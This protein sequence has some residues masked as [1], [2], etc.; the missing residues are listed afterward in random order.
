M[1]RTGRRL[2]RSGRAFRTP[3]G[4]TPGGGRPETSPR[5]AAPLTPPPPRARQAAPRRP[6]PAPPAG[7]NARPHSRDGAGPRGTTVAP[8]V[9][10]ARHAVSANR[11]TPQPAIA[12]ALSAGRRRRLFSRG[13]VASHLIN[14]R[15]VRRLRAVEESSPEKTV[16]AG[17][18]RGDRNFGGSPAAAHPERAG[19]GGDVGVTACE[20]P[21]E[22]YGGSYAPPSSAAQTSRPWQP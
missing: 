15:R 21:C 14:P 7:L 22:P 13:G 19:S 10:G 6:Q 5:P 1:R 20:P 12:G 2:R 16:A 11:A 17:V 3:A 9:A 8:A 4:R 18:A